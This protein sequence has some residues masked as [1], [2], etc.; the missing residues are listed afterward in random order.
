MKYFF[1][2]VF[3]IFPVFLSAQEEKEVAVH[4]SALQH[5]G[6]FTFGDKSIRFKKVVEDSRCPK[7]VTCIWAGEA[8]VLIEIIQKGA[9]MEERV[10]TVNS[11]DILLDFLEDDMLYFLN[12][13][14]LFPYP[15]TKSKIADCNYVLSV[16]VSEMV[17]S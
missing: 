3:L 2:F 7:D 6:Q 11:S 5:G 9:L 13:V 14:E 12:S 1:L 17:K 15:T 10:I 8:K 16:R 4:I